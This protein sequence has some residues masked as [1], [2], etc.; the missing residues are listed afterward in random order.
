M[1]QQSRTNVYTA[2]ILAAE[3]EQV[4]C[5]YINLMDHGTGTSARYTVNF[6]Q[7]DCGVSMQNGDSRKKQMPIHI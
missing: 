3:V 5:G 2:H 4:S 6:S 7:Y 1:S